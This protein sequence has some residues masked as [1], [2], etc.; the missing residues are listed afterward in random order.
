LRQL[1][2]VL[3]TAVE[4]MPDALADRREADTTFDG[5][6]GV[7]RDGHRWVGGHGPGRDVDR[8]SDRDERE[9]APGSG[10]LPVTRER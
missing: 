1:A 2:W 4:V 9:Y 6:R 3:V 7:P 8:L 5:G 10:R